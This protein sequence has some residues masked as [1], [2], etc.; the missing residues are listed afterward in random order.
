[1]KIERSGE[2]TFRK[3]HEKSSSS[4]ERMENSIRVIRHGQTENFKRVVR[5]SDRTEK[6]WITPILIVLL[7]VG[8]LLDLSEGAAV[9]PFIYTLLTVS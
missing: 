9:S 1:L 8:L 4:P 6:W 2:D 5:I 7:A 3:D